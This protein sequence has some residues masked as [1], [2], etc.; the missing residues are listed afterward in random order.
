M[1][2]Y[3]ITGPSGSGKTAIGI[4]LRKRGY[5]VV[6]ADSAFGYLADRNT[7]A[8]VEHPGAENITKQ[9][10][11]DNGWIWSLE[12]V[13]KFLSKHRGETV[14]FCGAADNEELFYRFFDKIFLLVLRPEV[15]RR[16]LVDRQDPDSNPVFIEMSLAELSG[17]LENAERF[18]MIVIWSDQGGV[19]TSADAVLEGIDEKPMEKLSRWVNRVTRPST[20][21]RATRTTISRLFKMKED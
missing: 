21:K 18:N 12:R 8:P 14:F 20:W 6:D 15:L 5:H 10:Y 4:E 7:G 2:A 1:A 19:R 11:D 17:S 9:W 3:L 16:R 13:E